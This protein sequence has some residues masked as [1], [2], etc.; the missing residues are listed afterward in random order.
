MTI[1]TLSQEHPPSADE[2]VAKLRLYFSELSL[3]ELETREVLDWDRDTN[4]LRRGKDFDT[5]WNRVNRAS[6]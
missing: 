2:A 5:M 1:L 4:V 6:R 3:Q